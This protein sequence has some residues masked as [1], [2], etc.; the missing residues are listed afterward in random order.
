M[1]K[2]RTTKDIIAFAEKW[3]F[4]FRDYG[5]SYIELV[6][7]FMADDCEELGF[8]MDCGH[9][10][11]EAYPGAFNNV[12]KLLKILKDIKDIS[13]LGSA[14]YSKWRYYNHWA[15][16]GSEILEPKNRSWFIIALERLSEIAL[17]KIDSTSWQLK[18]ITLR[19]SDSFYWIIPE[20]GKVMEQLLTIT[21]EGRVW[22]SGYDF[23]DEL[24]KP[25]KIESK[26]LRIQKEEAENILDKIL[27]SLYCYPIPIL[28]ACDV[29][30]WNLKV[31]KD[32][33]RT[34]TRRGFLLGCVE[35]DD[36]D[37][38]DLIQRTLKMRNL[39]AF[40]GESSPDEISKITIEYSC[41][42]KIKH[43]DPATEK[44]VDVLRLYSEAIILNRED[45]S[46]EQH[47]KI[48]TGC[49]IVKRIHV[50]NNDVSNFLDI[51]N[52]NEFFKYTISEPD[53]V[54]Q[55]E[56]DNRNYRITI[57]YQNDPSR[58]I[59]GTFDR[60]GLPSDYEEFAA[61]LAKLLKAYEKNG[62]INPDVYNRVKRRKDEYIFCSVKFKDNNKSYYYLADEDEYEVGDYVLV[63]LGYEN[64]PTNGKIVKVEYYKE[65]LTPYP[66]NKTKKIIRKSYKD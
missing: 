46:I 47:Q 50:E 18:K 24:D 6:D 55:R 40:G 27:L 11:S 19:S 64:N 48:G 44:L 65:E 66:I 57:D 14:I 36:V 7:H 43:F 58:V 37:L 26:Y 56:D 12:Q 32:D 52:S 9:A 30:F 4:K 45:Q 16:S 5:I 25:N 59:K 21:R 22:Y 13:L 8:E 42:S 62:I 31:T 34:E 35:V 54:I 49:N 17:G 53:D 10:F 3:S 41:V 38:T 39:F 29:G 51:I 15:Y 60:Y 20:P 33:D 61:E 23:P 63:P 1:E 2:K 28:S